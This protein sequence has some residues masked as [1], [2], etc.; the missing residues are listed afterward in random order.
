MMGS[1]TSGKRDSIQMNAGCYLSNGQGI[2]S[3]VEVVGRHRARTESEPRKS[4]T[5]QSHQATI[6]CKAPTNHESRDQ[7]NAK[8]RAIVPN[9]N[10]QD[11]T[12]TR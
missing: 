12:E 11:L 3:K 1:V 6:P 4:G 2:A 10:E 8:Y 7:A 5:A 9:P